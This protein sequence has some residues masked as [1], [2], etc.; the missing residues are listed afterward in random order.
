MIVKCL[1]D[2]NTILQFI[3]NDTFLFHVS[4]QKNDFADWVFATYKNKDLA[5]S[6]RKSK[7]RQEIISV[8]E[9]MK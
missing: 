9:N 7:D 8:I 4:P 3:D 6:I 2:L 1:R 5:I